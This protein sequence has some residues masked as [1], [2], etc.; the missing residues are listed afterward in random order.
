ME[1]PAIL[2]GSLFTAAALVAEHYFLWPQRQRIKRPIAYMIGTLT[3]GVGLS[4]T[5]L[6][7]DNWLIAIAYFSVLLPGGAIIAA[8]WW[9]RDELGTPADQIIKRVEEHRNAISGQSN[10]NN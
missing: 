10:R 5:S 6:I 3:I 7:L 8:L 4:I 9:G 1:F 2:A